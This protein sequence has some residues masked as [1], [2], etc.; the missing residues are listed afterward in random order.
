VI[1]A[2]IFSPLLALLVASPSGAPSAAPVTISPNAA[3]IVNSGST[4]IAGYSIAIRPNGQ[5]IVLS[6]SGTRRSL[7]SQ[8]T[9]RTLF[10][11][12]ATAL[13][14]GSL[15]VESCMKSA[16][17]GTT[18]RIL[19]RGQATP[20]LSCPPTGIPA[21]RLSHDIAAIENQVWGRLH[22]EPIHRRLRSTGT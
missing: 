18:T 16:S 17:F 8:A 19:W 20:D 12:L 9:T 11:D 15:A 5:V 22:I 6:A 14:L 13:P 10:R 3:V 21:T 7:L 1:A 4:N 2:L